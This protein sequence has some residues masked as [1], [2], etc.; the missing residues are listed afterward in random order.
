[1]HRILCFFLFY[2]SSLSGSVLWAPRASGHWSWVD[3][4]QRPSEDYS[5]DFRTL[6]LTKFEVGLHLERLDLWAIDVALRPDAVLREQVWDSRAGLVYR[7]SRKPE[8]MNEYFLKWYLGRHAHLAY[9]VWDSLVEASWQSTEMLEHGLLVH[10]P[11][12][13][14]GGKIYWDGII[15]GYGRWQFQLRSLAGRNDRGENIERLEQRIDTAPRMNDAHWGMA[16]SEGFTFHSGWTLTSVQGWNSQSIDSLDQEESVSSFVEETYAYLGLITPTWE[17]IQGSLDV[18]F[19]R[20]NFRIDG[21]Q[22]LQK[23]V[24]IGAWWDVDQNYRL[25]SSFLWGESD[26][27]QTSSISGYQVNVGLRMVLADGLELDPMLTQESRNQDEYGQR[28]LIRRM[29]VQIRWNLDSPS[30]SPV[31]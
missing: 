23:S 24:L 6:G 4:L 26:R 14:S 30:Y 8:L 15:E 21:S 27:W 3:Q 12:F 25:H 5:L 20:E 13:F 29:G 28:Q 11:R 16:V 10:F 17:H 31:L 22:V 7:E 1:M 18:R 2:S 9:G 19:A